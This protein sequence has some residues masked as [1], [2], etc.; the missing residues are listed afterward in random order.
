MVVYTCNAH[1][2]EAQGQESQMHNETQFQKPNKYNLTMRQS[3][4]CNASYTLGIMGK[5][6][7]STHFT[8]AGKLEEHFKLKD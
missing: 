3:L 4:K 1:T 8:R 5:Q 7:G 2:W 6:G